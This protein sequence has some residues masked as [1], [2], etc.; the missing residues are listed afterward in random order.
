M[1][2][3]RYR[4]HPYVPARDPLRAIPPS[5]HPFQFWVMVAMTLSGLANLLTP[6][7]E[8]LQEGLTP[9]YHKTWALTVFVSAVLAI[10]A[11]WWRDRIMG[12]LMERAALWS[13]G[14][15]CPIYAVVVYAQASIGAS[16]VGVT[17]T[18]SLGLAS[19]WRAVHVNRELKILRHFVARHFK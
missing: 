13:M 2:S 6:G 14:L 8:V 9:L 19:L 18:A 10:V 7:S 4:E 12:L 5:R 1:W 15:A 3:R 11:S 17:L 16:A